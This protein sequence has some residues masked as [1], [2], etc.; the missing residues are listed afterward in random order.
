MFLIMLRDDNIK[1]IKSKLDSMVKNNNKA[2][3]IIY[4]ATIALAN[5]GMNLNVYLD[6]FGKHQIFWENKKIGSRS[7]DQDLQDLVDFLNQTDHSNNSL[8]GRKTAMSDEMS[9]EATQFAKA[10]SGKIPISLVPPEIVRACAAVR[11]YGRDKYHAPNNWVLV[12]KQRYIDAMMR[13]LLSYLEGDLI[14]EESGL[15]HLWHAAC[16]M[17]FIIE[18]EKDN[19]EEI[20][21]RLMSADPKLKDQIKTY[22]DKSNESGD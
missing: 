11:A 10:D 3:T 14:D 8:K 18:M 2:N 19:W 17:S 20:K 7:Y 9:K 21:H 4:N 6:E 15:P 12:E 22:I 1:I 16:N 13:H 5:N